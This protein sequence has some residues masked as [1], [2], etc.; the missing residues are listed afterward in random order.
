MNII[1][2]KAAG[3]GIM[4]GLISILLVVLVVV[5]IVLTIGACIIIKFMEK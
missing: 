2:Y 4:T 5:L 3:E 1:N